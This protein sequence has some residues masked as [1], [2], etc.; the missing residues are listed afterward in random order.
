MRVTLAAFLPINGPYR[1]LTWLLL[2]ASSTLPLVQMCVA[3]FSSCEMGLTFI[4]P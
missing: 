3:C 2:L 4:I 1:P